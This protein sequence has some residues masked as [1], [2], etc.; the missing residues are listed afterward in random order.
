M[1]T[2]FPLNLLVFFAVVSASPSSSSLS[3]GGVNSTAII[4]PLTNSESPFNP[5]LFGLNDVLGPI[6]QI[7]YDSKVLLDI[8]QSLR[9]GLLRHPGGT[10]VSER[11][12]MKGSGNVL[13]YNHARLICEATVGSGTLRLE[14]MFY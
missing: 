4:S 14:R 2:I 7:P 3:S 11:F 13:H 8:V 1:I 5:S 12:L 6:M 10:V 9:V